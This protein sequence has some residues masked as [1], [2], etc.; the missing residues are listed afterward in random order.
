MML[1]LFSTGLRA[2]EVINLQAEDVDWTRG[3]ILVRR[4]KGGKFRV[5]PL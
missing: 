5:V 1:L 4:G 3:L 2:S